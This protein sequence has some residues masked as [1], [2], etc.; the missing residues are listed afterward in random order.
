MNRRK[1]FALA[2]T[3]PIAA[4]LI[5]NPFEKRIFLPPR[6]GWFAHEIRMREVLQYLINLDA[7]ILRHDVAWIDRNGEKQQ[8]HVDQPWDRHTIETLSFGNPREHAR[9]LAR[10]AFQ[11]IRERDGFVRAK[12]AVLPLPKTYGYPDDALYV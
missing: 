3:V 1:F 12:Q 7:F 6:G 8:Y 2:S 4:V 5:E 10:L 9:E 11:T